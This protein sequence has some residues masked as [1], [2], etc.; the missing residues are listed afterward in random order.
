MDMEIRVA[1]VE[2]DVE[3]LKEIARRL[4]TRMDQGFAEQRAAMER[5]FVEL[6][7]EMRWQ[8]RL[9]LAGFAMVLGLMGRIAGLY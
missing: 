8:L 6:R 7:K 9:M 5:G 1:K 2:V 4:E 3:S